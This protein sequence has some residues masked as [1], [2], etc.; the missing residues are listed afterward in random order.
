[1]QPISLTIKASMEYLLVRPC[2][3]VQAECF[4][5]LSFFAAL[6][7]GVN[8]S[9]QITKLRRFNTCIQQACCRW[10]CCVC[11]LASRPQN[12]CPPEREGGGS[13]SGLEAG[14][15]DVHGS[16]YI[17]IIPLATLSRHHGNL[18]LFITVTYQ[19]KL[20]FTY[21]GSLPFLLI[22]FSRASFASRTRATGNWKRN[23]FTN[24]R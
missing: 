20:Y 8:R 14:H 17:Y 9:V 18:C 3:R 16:D 24:V 7:E 22:Q 12:P 15:C 4:M 10:H 2:C 1:M 5:K 11:W 19:L 23:L 6:S 21:L 13:Y